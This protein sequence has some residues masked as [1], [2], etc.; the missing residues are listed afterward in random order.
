MSNQISRCV[1]C[2]DTYLPKQSTAE[3][4]DLYCSAGCEEDSRGS[5]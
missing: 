4:E 5:D 1:R 2:R 3:R